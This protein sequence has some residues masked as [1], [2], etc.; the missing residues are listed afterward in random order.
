MYKIFS[1]IF[2]CKKTPYPLLLYF[3]QIMKTPYLPVFY[4]NYVKTNRIHWKKNSQY[5]DSPTSGM[6]QIILYL[7]HG[8]P[9]E[10]HDFLS[11][12]LLFILLL[13]FFPSFLEGRENDNQSR[14]Q[15]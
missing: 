7:L 3:T 8:D 4:T 6:L 5:S 12:F 1:D 9:S 13:F 11:R 10:R 15:K 2:L 14:G